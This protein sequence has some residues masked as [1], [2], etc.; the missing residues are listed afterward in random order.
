MKFFQIINYISIF[1]SYSSKDNKFDVKRFLIGKFSP[2]EMNGV[3]NKKE[4]KAEDKDSESET[5]YTD[6]LKQTREIFKDETRVRQMTAEEVV[7]LFGNDVRAHYSVPSAIYAVLKGQHLVDVYESD[8]PFIRSLYFAISLMGD[9]DTIGCIAG[10]I[11]GALYAI[12]I[13][14][15]V[16]QN[17][18]EDNE[19]MIEY[20][21]DLYF[22]VM[23]E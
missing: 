3:N 2:F 8:N 23:N 15:E 5:P 21:N 13:I 1:L 10:N 14:P 4:N 20:A 19:V 6:K 9:T 17:R 16:M 12:D 18:C 7:H 22:Y 11:C